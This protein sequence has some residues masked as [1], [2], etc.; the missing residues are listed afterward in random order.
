MTLLVEFA[1]MMQLAKRLKESR[2]AAGLSQTELAKRVGVTPGAISNLERGDSKSMA[3]DHI[4]AA[5]KILR[6]SPEWL[7]TGRGTKDGQG[8]AVHLSTE[9]LML[10]DQIDRLGDSQRATIYAL[11]RQLAEAS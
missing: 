3:A 11:V 1:N 10:A 8:I 2:M 4:F 5:A 9:S 7:A 6:V